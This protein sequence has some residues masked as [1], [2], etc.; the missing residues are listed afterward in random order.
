MTMR[1]CAYACRS[2]EHLVSRRRFLTGAAAGA[3]A[4][5][6]G[7]L[8]SPLVARHLDDKDRRILAIFLSGGVSQLESWDPKPGTDTGGPFRAI[9]TTVP[10]VHISELLPLTARRMHLLSIIR[11]INTREDDHGKGAYLMTRG[12]REE[13]SMDYPHLGALSSCALAAPGEALPGYIR[14]QPGGGGSTRDAAYLG[15]RWDGIALGDGKP[16]A[17]LDR[18]ASLSD[19]AEARRLD[20]RSRLDAS[21]LQSRR[22]AATEAYTSSYDQ[23]ARLM[24]RRRVF[25]LSE[26][27]PATLAR[28]GGHEFGRHCLLARRLIENGVRFVQVTHTNYDTHFENFDFHIE[29]LAE[30]DRGFSALMDDLAQRG[31][32]SSTMV[33]VLSEFGRTPRINYGFGRDHWSKAW[34]IAIGGAGV[35]DGA[36]IGKTNDNG[37]EVVD[38]EVHHGHLFHTYLKAIG[39]DPL[40]EL[41]VGGRRLPL[42]NPADQAIEELLL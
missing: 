17:N 4:L 12:R 34:S 3:T 42:A 23:A 25:D 26:E 11:G 14:I 8:T 27:A 6:L 28:Y 37:T 7:G 29:Q 1:R 5:G 21:F 20:L 24:E 19:A 38:R 10:G 32:L 13:A 22:S 33:V 39:L 31:L 30:F 9:P 16:P 2:G 15:A 35:R 41:E 40:A 36:V 18:P